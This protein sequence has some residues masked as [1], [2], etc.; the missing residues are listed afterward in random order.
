MRVSE[1]KAL[2]IIL[3]T[4]LLCSIC[5]SS[6]FAE[7]TVTSDSQRISGW[8]EK[9]VQFLRELKLAD[10]KIFSNYFTNITREEFAM[11]SV[12]L[13]EKAKGESVVINDS[14]IFSDISDRIYK[15]DI[16]KAYQLKIVNGV[17]GNKFNPKGE[18]TRQEIAV[19]FFNTLKAIY[20]NW[21]YAITDDVKFK[22]NSNIAKWARNAMVYLYKNNIMNCVSEFTISPLSKASREQALTLDFRIAFLSGILFDDY[23]KQFSIPDDD[24]GIIEDLNSDSAEDYWNL[25]NSYFDNGYLNKSVTAYTKS[26]ELDPGFSKSYRERAGSYYFKKMYGEAINDA[27]K[28]IELKLDDGWNYAQRGRVYMQQG[29]TDEAIADASKGITLIK[30]KEPDNKDVAWI[31]IYRAHCLITKGQIKNAV[32]DFIAAAQMGDKES[33]EIL[34]LLDIDY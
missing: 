5:M 25:G 29:K 16:I 20:P 7:T 17:G 22:D 2:P 19:M 24:D 23:D 27:N 3:F 33:Q 13:Y 30:E 6:V 1:K 18:I 14:N 9:P 4:L 8:A 15:D 31:Y 28:A 32:N 12:K 21:E 26:I 10:E 34:G 11:L